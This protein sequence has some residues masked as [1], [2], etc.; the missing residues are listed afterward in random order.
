MAKQRQNYT[1]LARRYRPQQFADLIGQEAVA[2]ALV[3][4]LKTNRVAHAYLFT[5]TRGVGK[6]SAARILAKALNCVKGP[7]P[8]PCD[9]CSSCKAIAAGED[10]DVLEIDGASNRNL[11]DIREL[12]QN[13]QYKPIQSRFKIYI[14]DEVHQLTR[15]AFNALL[16]T[17]EEPPPHVKFIFATT[18]AQKVPATIL[19]RCQRFDFAG[20]STPRIVERLREVVSA[21]G[22]EADDEALEL[23]ARRA[24][25]SMRDAQSLLDQCLA[26]GGSKLTA[27]RVRQL[28]GLADDDLVAELAAAVLAKD[29]A[30]ALSLLDTA[31][32]SGVQPGE[33][34]EH[35]MAYWRDLLLV[36]TAGPDYPGLILSRRWH[37]ALRNQAEPLSV[38]DILTGLDLIA[39][40]SARLRTTNQGRILVEILLVRLGR[41]EQLVP[42]TDVASAATPANRA[43]TRPSPEPASAPTSAAPGQPP[44][45]IVSMTGGPSGQVVSARE[46]TEDSEPEASSASESPWNDATLNAVWD[47]VVTGVGMRIAALLE[48]AQRQ[49]TSGPDCLVLRFPSRYNR[50]AEELRDPE[51]LSRLESVLQGLMGRRIPA[52]VVVE[53]DKLAPAVERRVARTADQRSKALENPLVRKAV[54]LFGAQFV[55]ADEGFGSLPQPKPAEAEE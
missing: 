27:E 55:K 11:D 16:K 38:A 37:D 34:L 39:G 6:T 20:I 18:D 12:R 43:G 14:I 31:L 19:S 48:H 24:A 47:Q 50:D 49:A 52:R 10:V 44:R 45:R 36:K 41:L 13:V 3:N 17:L 1:V 30:K 23:I 2:Q 51:R 32:E 42:V 15:D 22:A 5:G 4:A 46:V 8:T 9:Q 29:V 26:F 53:E 25:H 7:T 33:L 54:D 35:L 28:L 21:E 40:T